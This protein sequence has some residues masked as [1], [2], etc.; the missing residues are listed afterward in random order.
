MIKLFHPSGNLQGKIQI[1]GSKSESNRWLILQA[2]YPEIKKINNLSN[3]EDTNTLRQALLEFSHQPSNQHQ[4]LNINIGHAGTAM[5]FLTA[6]F[7]IQT[8]AHIQLSGS[9]RMHQRPINP[10][11]EA[12]NDLG[13]QIEYAQHKDFPPLFIQGRNITKNQ[14]EVQANISSQ[15]ISSL[16]LVASKLPMGLEINLLGKITSKSYVEMTIH[17]LKSIGIQV[18]WIED[19]IK[20]Y[21]K[22]N[23]AEQEVLVES[24]WSSVAYWYAMVALS[25]KSHIR[26]SQF[27]S[28]SHQGDALVKELYEKYFGVR[29]SFEDSNLVLSKIDGFEYPDFI[30]LNLNSNPDLAQ[31]IVV[32]CA[33]LKIKLKLSGLKTLKIKETDRLQALYN[34]LNKLNVHCEITDESIS[35]LNS[36]E[37][38]ENT[39]IQTYE[40]HRM[41]MSFAALALKIPLL[42]ENENVVKKSY[43]NFWED[44]ETCG[45]Q[46]EAG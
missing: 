10:L 46:I 17:Q 26:I 39:I 21:P 33:A 29:T 14:V 22:Q 19:K 27:N 25:N 34:E 20:V 41:A 2:L 28:Q 7:A 43:L 11:V 18:D 8:D 15:F 44:L 45:F 9:E 3:S 32:T 6:F 42:I 4:P 13:A 12:L 1:S 23:I 30:E 31:S 36:G 5:R 24:D 40:D 38:K 16:L 35:I 37:W